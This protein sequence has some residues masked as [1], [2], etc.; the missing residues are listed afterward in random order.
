MRRSILAAMTGLLAAACAAPQQ[1]TTGPGGGGG[2]GSE[3]GDWGSSGGDWALSAYIIP[4]EQ[5]GL[6][7]HVSRP[8]YVAMFEIVPNAG[9]RLIYPTPG[10][11]R[12]DG[13]VFSGTRVPNTGSYWQGDGYSGGAY[14]R[15]G[16]SVGGGLDRPRFLFLIASE[17]PLDI[18]AF[19]TH[20]AGLRAMLGH[21]YYASIDPYATMERIAEVAL[22]SMVDDGTW[23]TDMYVYWPRVLREYRASRDVLIRCNGYT[24]Y[25]EY[26]Y[27][28]EARRALCGDRYRDRDRIA[29]RPRPRVP[30]APEA[31]GDS[32]EVE[33]PRRRTPLPPEEEAARRRLTSSRQLQQPQTRG[34][35]E[36]T[37]E[38]QRV[39]ARPAEPADQPADQP[40][41]RPAVG[42]ADRPAQPVGPPEG[43]TQPEQPRSVRPAPTPRSPRPA[44][45]EPPTPPR[46]RVGTPEHSSGET[47]RPRATSGD[48][49]PAAP[50][51]ASASPAQAR[52]APA[53]PPRQSAPR[54]RPSPPPA[55]Q[56]ETG[57]E[58]PPKRRGGGGGVDGVDGG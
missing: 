40:A 25:V 50:T 51:P 55:P 21:H 1:P 23:A 32:T 49:S 46:E 35:Q 57:E 27:A 34:P 10:V 14:G 47:R 16:Y 15:G 7:F 52:P 39:T 53:S 11:G 36:R 33:Q 41:N 3:G 9:T 8:A 31:G 28:Y 6:R 44:G 12:M 18:E 26:E 42:R 54:T 4:P 58:A 24:M 38:G 45:V 37:T 19:G 30:G 29:Q 20:G 48:P 13:F 56:R 5:G 17:R 22:P 43:R 2:W